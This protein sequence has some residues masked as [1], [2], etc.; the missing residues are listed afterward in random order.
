MAD[1]IVQNVKILLSMEDEA[2]GPS[3]KAAEALATLG[4]SSKVAAEKAAAMAAATSAASKATAALAAAQ[5]AAK[6]AGLSGDP[7]RIASAAG[8]VEQ[9]AAQAEQA[10]AAKV[11]A[12][13]ALDDARAAQ[14]VARTAVATAEREAAQAAETAAELALVNR[15]RSVEVET[16]VR[17]NAQVGE[18]QARRAGADGAALVGIDA[19]LATT[20]QLVEGHADEIAKLDQ[21][22]AR[23]EE[24]AAVAKTAAVEEQVAIRA[25]TDARL[26]EIRTIRDQQRASAAAA[27]AT[28]EEQRKSRIGS[29]L[30]AAN[31]KGGEFVGQVAAVAGGIGIDNLIFKAVEAGKYAI[32]QAREQEEAQARLGVALGDNLAEIAA[33]QQGVGDIARSSVYRDADLTSAAADLRERGVE[34]SQLNRTLRVAADVASALHKPIEEV[35]AEIAQ[36]FGGTIPKSLGRIVPELHQL[37]PAA[38]QAGA[39]LDVLSKA[40]DGRA[41]AYAA[42]DA[43]REE[44][45]TRDIKQEW[46]DLGQGLLRLKQEILPGVASGF[47]AI[48]DE[49]KAIPSA[50]QGKDLAGLGDALL[51]GT[52]D[53]LGVDVGDSSPAGQLRSGAGQGDANAVLRAKEMRDLAAAAKDAAAES[54]KVRQ[55]IAAD[56]TAGVTRDDAKHLEGVKKSVEEEFK[57]RRAGLQQYLDAIDAAAAQERQGLSKLVTGEGGLESQ[58]KAAV[59]D[60]ARQ[61]SVI[62][63]AVTDRRPVDPVA[64]PD[65]T[66]S[67]VAAN[68]EYNSRL[69]E[70]AAKAIVAQEPALEK[71]RDLK[72][73]IRS[74]TQEIADLDRK[75]AV[76]DGKAVEEAGKQ[77]AADEAAAKRKLDETLAL[78]RERAKAG[79]IG[80]FE[81]GRQTGDAVQQFQAANATAGQQV[82]DLLNRQDLTP[83]AKA[84]LTDLQATIHLDADK[85]IEDTHTLLANIQEIGKAAEDAAAGGMAKALTDV[86][87][88]AKSAHEALQGMI[89]GFAE[90]VL[91]AINQKIAAALVGGFIDVVSQA[92]GAAAKTSGDAAAAAAGIAAAK[93]QAAGEIPAYAAIGGAAAGAGAAA[94]AAATI[95]GV[96]GAPAAAA[97]AAN[98]TM[99]AI[100]GATAPAAALNAG[101]EVP[102]SGPN[103][104]S[105]YTHLTPGEFVF[106]QPVV[107]AIGLDALHAINAGR[108]SPV[109]MRAIATAAAGKAAPLT[110]MIAAD[111]TRGM[112]SPTATADAYTASGGHAGMGADLARHASAATSAAQSAQNAAESARD[113]ASRPAVAFI[114][115]DG[116]NAALRGGLNADGQRLQRESLAKVQNGRR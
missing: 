73:Q 80:P 39:A 77:A 35:S 13:A 27:A 99:S 94:A 90:A 21:K 41:A 102:G 51:G 91:G 109:T 26:V 42:T 64:H 33:V 104:D 78:I 16:V 50:L 9:A 28:T 100:I 79:E 61:Q 59:Q 18:L 2:S 7:T 52:A 107:R 72:Q 96:P 83:G 113:A 110:S 8:T 11:A 44:A 75:A 49:I 29:A 62:T 66:P 12:R 37:S 111:I 84:S 103:V 14:G 22:R 88:H 115:S 4:N 5:R 87:L 25:A 34:A 67:A 17:L 108:I 58:L 81:Q 93:A 40:Y 76:E 63:R 65:L 97:L 32:D 31:V 43:G 86:E 71:V 57:L 82:K 56:D 112:R 89:Q 95:I 23:L 106:Q 19:E 69:D 48:A 55:G 47:R 45:A 116:F 46:A 38:L 68:T 105:V 6:V 20:R 15:E 53:R 92:L 74:L 98:A 10:Q 70:N 3:A 101:G 85:A 114:H 60:V 24:T 54:L 1:D 30:Q 36:S